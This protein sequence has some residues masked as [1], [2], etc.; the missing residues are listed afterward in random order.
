VSTVQLN[1]II[2]WY[3]KE[4]E[5]G[6]FAPCLGEVGNAYKILVG[7]SHEKRPFRRP[8]RGLEDVIRTD[9][10]GTGC[11]I[12]T[13]FIR[14]RTECNGRLLYVAVSLRIAYKL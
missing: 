7:N 14:L 13:G 6:G 5:M 9:L 8:L 10:K 1:F 4:M 2:G 11:E 12:W 3:N